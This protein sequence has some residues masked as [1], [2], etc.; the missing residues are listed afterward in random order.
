MGKKLIK[1]THPGDV[2]KLDFMDP[3]GITNYRLAKDIKITPNAVGE[4]IRHKRGITAETAFKLSHYF[5]MDDP[6]FWMNLQARFEM[7]TVQDTIADKLS[8]ITPREAM[9]A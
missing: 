7:E 3:M 8:D 4:I 9:A 6:M 2:L 5:G 1:P